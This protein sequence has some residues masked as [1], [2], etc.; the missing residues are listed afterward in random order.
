MR[1]G[2]E[3]ALF[4][5]YNQRIQPPITVMEIAQK[6]GKRHEAAAILSAL[7]PNGFVIALDPTGQVLD[8]EAFAQKLS[9]VGRVSF[10]IGGPDGLD[11]AVLAR[12]NLSLSLGAMT[13]PHM[14]VR[15][16]LAE[17]VF[18]AR[19]IAAGHPYHR[20]ADA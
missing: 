18:R 6:G 8:S 5:H 10:V 14:L 9:A 7:P 16:M 4:A 15:G 12:A 19:S 13:W 17:Q 1:P 2:V 11:A 20:S 3:A